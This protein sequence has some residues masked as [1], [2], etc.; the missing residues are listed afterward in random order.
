M[1]VLYLATHNAHKLLEIQSMLGDTCEVR[2][3]SSLGH[4]TAPEESASTLLGNATIKAQALYDLYHKPC[5]ADDTGLFVEALCGDP[6]VHSA[7]Y[8]GRDGDDVANRKHLLDS[9]ASHPEPWRAYFECVI[10]LID[11]QGEEHHFVGRVAG[12]IID[13][14]EGAEGFGYDSLFV[15]EDFDKTFA[16]MSPQEK[17]AISHRTRAVD[18]LRTYLTKHSL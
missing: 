8:A 15:P 18:Q 14:E 7:R 11:S 1:K 13:H 12:R 4:Y 5:I 10:V 17:N 3:A 16:M 2:S 9:L 6:G